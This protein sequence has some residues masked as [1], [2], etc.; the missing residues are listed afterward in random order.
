MHVWKYQDR[1]SCIYPV[2]L[3][4]SC[5]NH[6]TLHGLVASLLCFK[7]PLWAAESANRR[8]C[9]HF[10]GACFA[11]LQLH[12]RLT[13]KNSLTSSKVFLYGLSAV[14]SGTWFLLWFRLHRWRRGEGKDIWSDRIWHKLGRFSA[15]MSIGCLS[16]AIGYAA[17]I[18]FN[19][20]W[21]KI[22]DV[23]AG[24][25]TSSCFYE[26]NTSRQRY[27]VV[28]NFF[29]PIELF[30]LVS[31]MNMLLRRIVRHASHRYY[32]QARD[33]DGGSYGDKFDFR[34]CIGEYAMAKIHGAIAAITL[35]LNSL[36][37]VARFVAAAGRAQ[38]VVQLDQA[39]GACSSNCNN[40]CFLPL[41]AIVEKEN[42]IIDEVVRPATSAQQ[43]LE[44][45]VLVIMSVSF[46]LFFP[47]CIVMFAR[48]ERR[49]AL[50]MQEMDHRPDY[51]HVFLPFEFT[52]SES[53]IEM[54]AGHARELL[55]TLKAT[56]ASRR[57]KF[58]L[59][60]LVALVCFAIRTVFAVL[61]CYAYVD[62]PSVNRSCDICDSSCQSVRS[63]IRSWF[64]NSLEV[65]PIV[66]S[67]CSALPQM[68]CLWLMMTKEDRAWLLSVKDPTQ[69]M[70]ASE[71]FVNKQ[72]RRMGGNLENTFG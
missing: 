32:N 4:I 19:R 37:V 63:M 49:L 13:W 62:N 50:I 1:N 39:A 68:I 29:Y 26:L 11:F 41:A 53:Q 23:Q 30:C 33:Q 70:S 28:I 35:V 42:K 38:L 44:A 15:L 16:G 59:A 48:V 18:E 17:R 27:A 46:L 69:N 52:E 58:T 22:S 60:L 43:I 72:L 65:F 36:G 24:S 54:Q 10:R 6:C 55:L 40:T 61:I 25:D 21:L 51:G 2:Y 20:L 34:D 66:T 67:L 71:L 57:R 7:E 8:G 12:L 45:L 47:A 56:S 3:C 5:L 14:F 64:D 31:N 9:W